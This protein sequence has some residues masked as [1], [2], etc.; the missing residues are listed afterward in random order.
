M[1]INDSK[2]RE[3][4]R[5]EAQSIEERCTGYRKVLADTLD[6]IIELE[7]Q[8]QVQATNIQQKISD[9]CNAAGRWLA[10]E[11]S[12]PWHSQGHLHGDVSDAPGEE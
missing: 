2:V 12:R 4:I 3:I 11:G 8:H 5:E 6:H 10:A 9:K 1:P 7:W